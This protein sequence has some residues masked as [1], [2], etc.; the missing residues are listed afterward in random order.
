MGSEAFS[1][2]PKLTELT[3]WKG[4]ILTQRCLAQDSMLLTTKQVFKQV[5]IKVKLK[6]E[7]SY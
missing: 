3:K 5:E 7:K 4:W 1:N 6:Q 2:L